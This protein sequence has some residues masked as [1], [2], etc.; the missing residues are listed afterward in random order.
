VTLRLRL[1]NDGAE[2]VSVDIADFDSDLGNFAVHPEVLSLAP[3][4][5]AEPD[6]MISQLGVTA[7]DIPV[8]VTLKRGGKSET[9]V[10][11]VKS[12]LLPAAT[13]AKP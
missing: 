2:T 13:A 4:Q 11:A 7:D 5:V 6:P 8:T 12:L 3:G 10:I 1:E 9:R